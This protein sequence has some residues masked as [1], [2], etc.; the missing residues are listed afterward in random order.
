MSKILVCQHV[1]YEILGTFDPLLRNKGFRIKFVN[2]G[3]FPALQP[4]LEGYDG[5]II[6][7]GPMNVDQED[8]FSHLKF[9][10]QLIL[11]AIN[12]DIP[13]L[14]ICL[15]A[16]LIASALGGIVSKAKQ[17]EIG[18]YPVHITEAGKQDPVLRCFHNTEQIFQ[19]HGDTFTVPTGA[20][21]LATAPTCHNQ[22]F[23][24]GDRVYAFQFHL[25][26]DEPLIERWLRVAPHRKELKDL[27][28]TI[29]PKI[30]RQS[31][32]ENIDRLKE[33]SDET[34]SAF[35]KLFDHKKNKNRLPS[36]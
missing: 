22:A 30:I 21:L 12:K 17:K 10:K 26:V 20:T 9:E 2:F 11:D 23:R 16:Q 3:R 24:Y 15:G 19:W 36:R 27:K 8:L 28:G 6:L 34:F 33:L 13:V 18:W 25:E 5:L 29:D 7:G 31:T 14:G 1:P 4:S 32:P 35:I